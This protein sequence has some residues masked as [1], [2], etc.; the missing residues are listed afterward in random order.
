M[1]IF[2]VYLKDV[3]RLVV[4]WAAFIL[5]AGLYLDYCV[6]SAAQKSKIY[7]PGPCLRHKD[8]ALRD[9]CNQVQ[10]QGSEIARIHAILYGHLRGAN[11]EIR[12]RTQ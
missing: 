9:L 10:A 1:K 8:E 7:E 5:G 3:L 11:E 2:N 12:G 4:F 6:V